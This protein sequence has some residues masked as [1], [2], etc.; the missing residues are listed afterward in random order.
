MVKD[1]CRQSALE[2]TRVSARRQGDC[3]SPCLTR[4]A[5]AVRSDLYRH[6]FVTGLGGGRKRLVV[7]Y[8]GE[9]GVLTTPRSH[10]LENAALI[11]GA[12]TGLFRRCHFIL[13]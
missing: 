9:V 8:C 5:F 3:Q 4:S 10:F 2:I 7:R 1:G 13:L 6:P 11:S 12:F